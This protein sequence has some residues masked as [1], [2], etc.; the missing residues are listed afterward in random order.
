MAGRGGGWVVA[1]VEVLVVVWRWF[2]G[3]AIVV[4]WKSGGDSAVV[5][6]W[7][8][9]WTRGKEACGWSWS[10]GRRRSRGAGAARG[11]GGGRRDESPGILDRGPRAGCAR[12]CGGGRRDRGGSERRARLGGVALAGGGDVAAGAGR[13]RLGCA[14][15]CG[16]PGRR[17]PVRQRDGDHADPGGDRVAAGR[18]PLPPRRAG[19]Y[20][21]RVA[22]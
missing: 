11:S 7:V 8:R 13:R 17:R 22:R 9:S 16:R 18:A 21:V 5:R 2:G 6:R 12:G 19:P 20:A 4:R 15:R 1:S 3:G 14:R 10:G